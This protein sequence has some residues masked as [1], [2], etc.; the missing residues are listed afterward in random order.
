MKDD[1]MEDNEVRKRE[2]VNYTSD[3]P[4]ERDNT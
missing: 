1:E 3:N 4:M 2:I